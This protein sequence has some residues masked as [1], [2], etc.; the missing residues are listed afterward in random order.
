[1]KR[2][3]HLSALLITSF[4]F[5][6]S[7]AVD[8]FLVLDLGINGTE[9]LCKY[10]DNNVYSF[11]AAS[12][13]PI[14]FDVSKLVK[15]STSN[16]SAKGNCIG[17]AGLGGSCYSGSGG[18]LYSGPGGGLCTGPGGGLYSGPGGGL[19]SGPGGGL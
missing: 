5:Q 2:L 1:M 12:L 19:Y 7:F 17:Y 10:S 15:N 6:Q 4:I 13:C 3:F 9:H 8:I 11:G 16:E 18:G 14:Q